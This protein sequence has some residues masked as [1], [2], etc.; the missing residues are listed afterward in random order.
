MSFL[1]D[2]TA[3]VADLEARLQNVLQLAKVI[4][5]DD[6]TNLVDVMIRGVDLLA[7]PYLTMRAGTNG[8]TYWVPEVGELGLLLCPGGDVGNAVFLPALNYADSTAPETDANIMLR[9]FKETIEEKWNGNDDTYMLRIGGDATRQTDKDPAKIEDTAGGSKLTIEDGTTKL[10]AS[11][12]SKLEIQAGSAK[13]IATVMAQLALSAAGANLAGATLFTTGLTGFTCG[14]GPVMFAPVPVPPTPPTS[15]P[16]APAG[17]EPDSD[18]NPTKVPPQTITGIAQGAGT[19]TFTI[20]SLVVTGI[21]GAVSGHWTNSGTTCNALDNGEWDNAD[22]PSRR[23]IRGAN[24]FK[25]RRGTHQRIKA[26]FSERGDDSDHADRDAGDAAD[27]W[28]AGCR[29]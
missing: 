15:P 20:P 28:L 27:V 23:S 16:A 13:L 14:V 12:I 18:G 29:V 11:P 25:K 3:R 21:A 9:I 8:K 5:V 7:V 4:A 2:L 17:S 19:F 10:E 24:D 6:Q 1:A 26:Y 22:V